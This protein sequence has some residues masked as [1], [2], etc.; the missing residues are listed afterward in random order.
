MYIALTSPATILQW[1]DAKEPANI[2]CRLVK[3]KRHAL[4]DFN[5]A[6]Q[7]LCG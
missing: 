1:V 3:W 2:I 4:P 5:A 7:Q 6:L